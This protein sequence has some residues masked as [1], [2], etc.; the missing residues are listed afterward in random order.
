MD[1]GGGEAKGTLPPPPL[2]LYGGGGLPPSS[3]AYELWVI[4][5]VDKTAD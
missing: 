2:K 1:I 4:V 5:E 3:Y